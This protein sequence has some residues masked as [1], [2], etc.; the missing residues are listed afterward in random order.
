MEK[1]LRIQKLAEIL[2]GEPVKTGIKITFDGTVKEYK[3][4][5]IP[6]EYLIYNK[7]NGRIGTL[8]RSYEKQFKVLNPENTADI[9]VIEKFLL[10]SKKEKNEYTEKDIVKNSQREHGIVTKDGIIIDGNRRAMLLNKIYA[11]AD[12]WKSEMKASTVIVDGCKYF[13]AVILPVEGITKEVIKLETTYQMGQDEK[14]DYNPI[15]KY[16]KCKE[17]R[18]YDYSVDTIAEMMATKPEQIQTWLDTMELMESYLSHFGYDGIYTRLETREDLFLNLQEALEKY[19]DNDDYKSKMVTWEYDEFEVSNLKSIA[20]DYIRALYEGKDFR[21]IIKR[22]KEGSV[23]CSSKAVWENFKKTH[24]DTIE[25]ITRAER[26]IDDWVKDSPSAPD[27]TKLLEQ[28]DSEWKNKVEN[29]MQE[30]LGRSKWSLENL[31]R[32]NE[33]EKILSRILDNL[34]YID[35]ENE[36]LHTE[37][38]CLLLKEIIHIVNGLKKVTEKK[39]KDCK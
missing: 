12:Y 39:V 16:L 23:F 11:N 31:S 33:P 32:A 2:R 7:S 22:S 10:E 13:E 14:L 17:L 25:P 29:L 34:K 26:S 3:T 18:D 19:V 36:H 5:R 4:Y 6:L 15:E 30:N 1:H 9:K 35:P 38:S 28:R 8:V 21:N 27:K 24:S 37:S 20:F